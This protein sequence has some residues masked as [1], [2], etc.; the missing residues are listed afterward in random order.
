MKQAEIDR[1]ERKINSYF[2]KVKILQ[3]KTDTDLEVVSDLTKYL[4]I[5]VSG[6]YEKSFY[7]IL[8]NHC[9]TKSAG[10]ISRYISI[11]LSRVT[12]LSMVKTV[13][14]MEKFDVGWRD[15]ITGNQRYDEYKA[16]LDT[17]VSQR[18]R[19]AHGEESNISI[20]MLEAY[21]NSCHDLLKELKKIIRQPDSC[22]EA[23]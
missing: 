10:N 4:C 22:I 19:I 15:K 21:Y 7:Y 9:N 18:N 20:A 6:Y 8:V 1:L 3:K 2:G 13:K 11:T 16:A 23:Q 5:I 17:L 12:N 14:I